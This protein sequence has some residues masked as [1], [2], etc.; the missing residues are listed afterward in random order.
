MHYLLLSIVLSVSVSVLLKL[1][2]RYDLDIRQAIAVN[3]LVAALLTATFMQ[4]DVRSLQDVGLSAW[5]LLL[6]LGAGLPSMFWVLALA[7]R[8]SG[9]VRTDAAMRLSLLLPLIAA[10]T[11]FDQTLSWGKGI[12]VLAGLL[13]VILIVLRRR[14]AADGKTP[15][16]SSLLLVV[17]AGM[18][19]IDIL[20]KLM[21]R[22]S[23]TSSASVLLAAFCL[24][25]VLSLVA[26]ARLYTQGRA[27][28]RLRHL[29]AGLALGGL[30]FGNIV[31]YI[32][33]HRALPANPALVFAA[34]NIGVIVLATL[35]GTLAFRERLGKANMAGLVLAV[36]AVVILAY[37]P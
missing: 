26:V 3:Y 15:A 18:G 37:T 12:G 32:Q 1:A 8:R 5:G 33:A 28:W 10:F 21:A 24:A 9:V 35:V 16:W 4:P 27:Q 11:V 25:A 20:F 23:Q 17:F 36:I 30:N 13:A 22:L 19:A 31:F 14:G 2:R 7:V 6:V 34:M 29:L